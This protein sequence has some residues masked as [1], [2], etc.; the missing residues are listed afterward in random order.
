MHHMKITVD[1]F[2][3]PSKPGKIDK[4]IRKDPNVPVTAQQF[5]HNRF[6]FPSNYCDYIITKWLHS[7]N[8]FS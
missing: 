1:I 5:F 7:R 8:V 2:F 4:H 6:S 3:Q